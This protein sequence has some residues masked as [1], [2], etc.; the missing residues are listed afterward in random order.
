MAFILALVTSLKLF[1][2]RVH[3]IEVEVSLV[4]TSI[5]SPSH[6]FIRPDAGQWAGPR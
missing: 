3:D 2:R 5:P 1:Y 6:V 4:R